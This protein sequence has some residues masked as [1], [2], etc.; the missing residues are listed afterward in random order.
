MK[1][2]LVFIG[3][4]RMGAA[5]SAHLVEQGYEIH[6]YDVNPDARTKATKEGVIVYDS[7]ESAVKAMYGEK[8]VW[9]MVPSKFVEDVLADITPHLQTDDCIID[10]GNGFFK[11]SIKRH[12]DFAVR[13]INFID[14]GTSGGVS[15]A[16]HGASLMVG[17]DKEVVEK[18][19]HI[20]KALATERGY[21]F[22]GGPG[23]GHFVKMIHNGIEYG[24]MGALAEGMSIL[25]EHKGGLDINLP[26]VIKAYEHG[27]IIS[28]N[29]VSWLSDAY[30]TP[31]YLEQI[32]GEVPKGETEMEME[33]IVN[34]NRVPVLGAA[35]EQ[36]KRTRI[37][38]SVTGTLISAMRNKF[39]GQKTQSKHGTN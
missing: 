13:G 26:E 37:E 18:Y 30:N 9:M 15:G 23:A 14:C 22:V 7:P 4:G 36:R 25:E 28:S 38:P 32:A 39:G 12:T 35:L 10:G 19:Q 8:V 2:E 16:R 5:M 24:M 3:L 17:G 27:S 6:G 1:K 20:F 34:H 21:G 31:G 29:L 33:Y 11:D